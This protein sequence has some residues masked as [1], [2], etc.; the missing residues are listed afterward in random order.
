MTALP[1][2]VESVGLYASGL[3]EVA[4]QIHS[5]A[6]PMPNPEGLNLAIAMQP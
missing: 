4:S 2:F 5:N 3:L 1:L 6:H